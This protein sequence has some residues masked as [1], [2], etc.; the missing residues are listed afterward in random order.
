MKS[1]YVVPAAITAV[2][3]VV[4]SGFGAYLGG[5]ATRDVV[6]TEQREEARRI[7]AEARGAARVLVSELFTASKEM[8]D[9]AADGYFHPFDAGFRVQISQRDL[10]LIAARLETPHWSRVYIA[11][12]DIQG[13]ERY[14]RLRSRPQHPL[15]REPLARHT[16]Q[17]I[18][19]DMDLIA[20]AVVALKGLA[21]LEE[22]HVPRLDVEAAD[23][24]LAPLRKP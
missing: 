3:A 18:G 6:Q 2:A 7:D 13:L 19:I 17:L 11:L 14:V 1:E 5:A 16:L 8:A 9:F 12:S 22:V 4:A 10:R 15:A 20:D 21:E 23:R 24:R